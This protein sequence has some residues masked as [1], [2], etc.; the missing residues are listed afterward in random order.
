MTTST[1]ID[2]AMH[3]GIADGVFPAAEL[4]VGTP[5]RILHHNHY[6]DC[7]QASLFDIASI[8]KV[9]CTTTLAMI[10]V[11]EGRLSLTD[12][13]VNRISLPQHPS[14]NDICIYHL[15]QHTS[16]L[17]AHRK[18]YLEIPTH[19]LGKREAHDFILNACAQEISEHPAG[20]QAVYSDIGF[21]LLGRILEEAWGKDL[22]AIFDREIAK[23][24]GLNATHFVRT[25]A[26]S[27]RHAGLEPASKLPITLDSRLRGNDVYVPTE[28]CSWR[29]HIVRGISRDEN[30]YAMGGV[31]GHAGL[32]SNAE[33]LHQFAKLMVA[34]A[35]GS[36]EFLNPS[37][38]QNFIEP[39]T[40]A[41]ELSTDRVLGWVT[42]TP[43]NSSAG[44]HFSKHSIGHSGFTGCTL[45]IDLQ[46]KL[47]VILLTNRTYPTIENNKIR[48][49]RPMFHDLIVTS[50][51]M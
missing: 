15:L 22:D 8:T 32:F 3:Q 50:L 18:F 1:T 16:G 2:A 14:H 5:D 42:P 36:H 23:P 43:P 7:H 37:V 27:H 6:G 28:D 17:P 29:K 45:W 31:A 51:G 13:L 38:V 48:E 26:K 46:K 24:W 34:A 30:C 33:D 40:P 4:L 39:T 35:N 41:P 10:A 12:K 11:E 44:T 25:R 49:F 19:D 47:W 21:I 9:V 20:Q